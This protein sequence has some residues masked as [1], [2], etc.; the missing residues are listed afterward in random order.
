MRFYLYMIDLSELPSKT[1]RDDLK[2]LIIKLS[3]KPHFG[4][5]PTSCDKGVFSFVVISH[6]RRPIELRVFHVLV[7]LYIMLRCTKW[8]DWS[9]TITNSVSPAAG[10]PAFPFLQVGFKYLGSSSFQ[11]RRCRM[12]L[13]PLCNTIRRTCN[14]IMSAGRFCICTRVRLNAAA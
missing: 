9:L 13:C 4:K 12:Q 10:C 11:H 1:L 8:E 6:L 14:A 5:H 2:L 7:I 3:I